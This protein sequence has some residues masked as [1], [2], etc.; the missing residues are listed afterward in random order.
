MLGGA[1]LGEVMLVI[2][3]GAVED[4]GRHTCGRMTQRG[5]HEAARARRGS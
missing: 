1:A 2:V 3:L 4:G 5:G